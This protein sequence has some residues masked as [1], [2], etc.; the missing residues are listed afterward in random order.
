MITATQSEILRPKANYG[1]GYLWLISV[2]A[3]MGGLLFGWDWVVIGGAKPFFQRYFQL[4][5]EAQIGWANS[6]A[7]IGCLVGALSAGAFSD[8]FGRKRLLV[9]AALLF[10]VTSLGNA[11]A[12]SFAVFIAWRI[13]GGVAI[14]L[15]SNLSPMYIAE[16][17]P[18]Q[19][20]GRLVAINQLTVV[21]GIL[22]A[23]YINWFLV[24]NLPQ[25]ATDDFIRTSWFGQ[26]GWRW[27]FG[28]TAVP[29]LLFFLG[30]LF[31]PESP[32]WL[33]KNGKTNSAR[34]VLAKIGGEDYANVA[35]TEIQSTLASEEIQHVRFA[36]LLEP[37]MRKVIV[38]GVVLAVFQ[39][40]CGINVIFNYAE[41]IF[42]AAGYDIS[43]V[44]KNIAWTGSVNLVFTLV[45]LGVVDRGGRRPL[46]LFG[47]A[48]L[49]VIYLALGFCYFSGVKGLPM[50][51]L[52]LAAIGSYAMSLAPVVWVVISEIF[53]NRIRGA[54]MA[55]AVSSLWI[56]CFLLTFSF[57]V[58]NKILGSAGIFW[59]YAGIC[60][61][62]F[63]FI[64]FKLPE[65]K[66]KTLEQIERELVG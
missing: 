58:L 21:I 12:S 61:A 38:L 54:A 5:S 41:E 35:A 2:V 29:S 51:L 14:G 11:L 18:A 48:A 31:V 43:S 23:Q 3:A 30:M 25:G 42:R 66:G 4:T 26:Q 65:T 60:V 64:K 8:K 53:P 20:R 36:D 27:M 24:R 16:V 6:C 33:A 1:F 19:I 62:G 47:S 28:M 34:N 52:V 9:A 50:L 44:L 55:V 7:L 32:R 39:Q 10:A 22:L 40:W 15:A 13:S 49:A 46:M 37:K 57:P 45:A 56:A 63:L 59:L 17:A